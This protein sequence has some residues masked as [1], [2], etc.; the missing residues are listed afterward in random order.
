MVCAEPFHAMVGLQDLISNHND[1]QI[2][3]ASHTLPSHSCRS[4]LM[5]KSLLLALEI[6][7][8]LVHLMEEPSVG[9]VVCRCHRVQS[10]ADLGKNHL[11]RSLIVGK[12][13]HLCRIF[14]SSACVWPT[15]F[16]KMNRNCSAAAGDSKQPSD[17]RRCAV[18]AGRRG[19]A[20]RAP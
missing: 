1:E 14:L 2:V 13:L 6:S 20:P 5:H 3:Q 15:H 8:R 11:V 16:C 4:T 19:S 10:A 9:T 17:D 18:A 12:S 7:H